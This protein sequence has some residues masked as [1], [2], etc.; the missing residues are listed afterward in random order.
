MHD[1]EIEIDYHEI[2]KQFELNG[3]R[4]NA[5][6]SITIFFDIDQNED[7]TGRFY[8]P[9][10]VDFDIGDVSLCD[11]NEE[12]LE[13]DIPKEIMKEIKGYIDPMKWEERMVER[14]LEVK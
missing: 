9:V 10:N 6:C 2:N 14:Y 12:I 4:Y 3:K 7:Y 8:E 13:E 11:G 5:F 1:Y